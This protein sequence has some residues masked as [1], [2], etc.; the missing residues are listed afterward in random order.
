MTLKPILLYRIEE[1]NVYLFWF[2]KKLKDIVEVAHEAKKEKENELAKVQLELPKPAKLSSNDSLD[3]ALPKPCAL[4]RK[5]DAG[6]KKTKEPNPIRKDEKKRRK[7]E[8]ELNR[9][10]EELKKEDEEDRDIT[11][12]KKELEEYEIKQEREA[13]SE[14]IA[15]QTISFI[16]EP[17]KKDE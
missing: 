17:Q 2:V 1:W 7:E 3:I 9:E 12:I 15:N 5:I 16:Q 6:T 10:L 11:E 8:K 4:K 13:R 14:L